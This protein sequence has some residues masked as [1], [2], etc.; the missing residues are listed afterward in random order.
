M[1]KNPYR[2]GHDYE[3]NQLKQRTKY[4]SKY[5]DQQRRRLRKLTHKVIKYKLDVTSLKTKLETLGI[6]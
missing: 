1:T 5:T 4:W 3:L 2:F 6:Y